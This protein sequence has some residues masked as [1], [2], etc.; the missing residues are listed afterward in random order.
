MSLYPSGYPFIFS[1]SSAGFSIS[2]WYRSTSPPNSR[3]GS[4]PSTRVNSPIASIWSIH[5]RR[6][7]TGIVSPLSPEGGA[8]VRAS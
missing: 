3:C 6:S 7:S 2:H 8:P 1:N 5:S 4:A